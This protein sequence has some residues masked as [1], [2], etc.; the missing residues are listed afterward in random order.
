MGARNR[1]FKRRDVISP[2]DLLESIGVSKDSSSDAPDTSLRIVAETARTSGLVSRFAESAADGV[3]GPT[4]TPHSRLRRRGLF[5][6]K[7]IGQHVAIIEKG[8]ASA[9]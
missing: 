9:N 2:S 6:T 4:H 7:P 1:K 3:S 5:Q 8:Y